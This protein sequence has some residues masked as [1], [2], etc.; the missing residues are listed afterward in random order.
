MSID[1]TMLRAIEILDSRA[2]PTLSVTVELAGGAVARAGVPSGASTGS[3]EAVELRDGD[4][5]R[6]GGQGVRTAVGHVN[7]EIADAV[8]GRGFADQTALDQALIDLDGTPN[9]SRLGANAVIG[10]SM[11]VARATAAQR[12]VPLWRYL[13]PAG[14]SPL[15]PVPHFNVLNGGAHATNPLDFQEFMIAPLGAPDLAE[16]VRAGAEV[17]AA[18]RRR[19]SE[20]GH[21]TG[22]GDEGGFAP[23]L[24]RPEDALTL[25]VAAIGDA[26]YTP[27]R[28]GVAIALDPAASEFRQP[29]GTYHVGGEKLT[30][31]DLIARYRQIVEDFP[32]WSIEDG[33]GEDD[34]DGWVRLTEHLGERVQLVGDDNFVTNPAVIARGID[35]G[36]ANASLIKL[37][38]IGTVTETLHAMAVCR[39]AGYGAMVSHRSGETEDSF[40]A[41]LAVGS[42]CGQIKTGAPARGERVAK[43]NRLLEIAAHH[44]ALP[45]G[46]RP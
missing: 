25:L 33:L 44:P 10:V 39:Q 43:Y 30:S 29:D 18:L 28:D 22:L 34:H 13:G 8:C 23:D 6:Y 17:Y 20:G 36:I 12:D 42:G 21:S 5:A 32:V 9:K 26:G 3:G 19:L 40:I 45:F 38:Q 24:S 1:I 27:G 4:P 37:N 31:E 2:R 7:G 14:V 11:A 15:L 35:D 41:D 16:A 46:L